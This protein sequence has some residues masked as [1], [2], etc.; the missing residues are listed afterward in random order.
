MLTFNESANV[1]R[2]LEPLRWAERIIVLDSGSS[3]NTVELCR[4]F[5]NV[6]VH[7]RRFDRHAEQWNYGVS[8]V[9][10]DWVLALDADYVT[11]HGLR[12]ELESTVVPPGT[13]AFSAEFVYCIFGKPLRASLYPPRAVLFR[14]DM[15]RYVQDGHTQLL[16]LDG[17]AGRLRTPI[18]HDDRKPLRQWLEAQDR[19]AWL[20]VEKLT[21]ANAPLGLRDSMRKWIFITPILMPFYCLIGQGLLFDGWPGVHYSFQRTIAETIL[22]LRLIERQLT[23]R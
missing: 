22:S 17:V 18:R 1:A 8:L 4:Q 21:A 3:D 5:P 6:Q 15:A 16:Q 7:E 10:T 19:Y 2:T 11:D 12:A 23:R 13:S 14:R 9:E 20:E